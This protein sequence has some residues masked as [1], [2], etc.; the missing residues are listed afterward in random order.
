MAQPHIIEGTW[1]EIAARAHELR[2]YES[3]TLIIPADNQKL[4]PQNGSNSE[5][6]L[7]GHQAKPRISAMGKYAGILSS[8][9]F[10]RSK[11]EEIEI[12]D[13]T[14]SR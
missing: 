11:Q 1:D 4:I 10:M 14:L 2:Q 8:D 6:V 7:P 9:D 3:L 5:T 12:E 13:R